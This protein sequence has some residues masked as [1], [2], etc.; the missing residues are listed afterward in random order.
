MLRQLA[1]FLQRCVRQSH[2]FVVHQVLHAHDPPQRLAL[3]IAVGVF[4]GFTPTVGV[5]MPL[6]FF[7]AWLLRA[8]KLVGLP[9]VW[10]SNPATMVPMMYC[11][12]LVGRR[13]LNLDAVSYAWWDELTHPPS[14]DRWQFYWDRLLQIALPLWLGS[15]VVGG[16]AA[17]IFYYISFWLIC[18]YR[19]R[20]WGHLMPPPPPQL[21]PIFSGFAGKSHGEAAGTP[22]A[23]AGSTED[24]PPLAGNQETFDARPCDRKPPDQ[25]E[26]QMGPP[27]A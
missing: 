17:V 18:S 9:L 4:V 8:N 21:E 16:L 15:L 6:C 14:A 10:I 5:Q 23:D 22:P 1:E 24:A 25:R 19:L 11:C 2:S 27:A 26:R 20:R 13:M 7:L 3:G 12:Y